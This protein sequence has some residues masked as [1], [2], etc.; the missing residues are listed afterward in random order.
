MEGELLAMEYTEE[1]TQLL[2]EQELAEEVA[3]PRTNN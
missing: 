1:I 3:F 2:L